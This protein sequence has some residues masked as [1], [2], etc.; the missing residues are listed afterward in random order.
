MSARLKSTSAKRNTR[1]GAALDRP[2]APDL[3]RRADEI[4]K[5]YQVVIWPE[6]GGYFGRGVEMP[7]V[8]ADGKTPAACYAAVYE[9]LKV[10]V[11]TLL[12]QGQT[13][14]PAATEG[15]RTEQVNVRLTP[16]ERLQL[17][18]AAKQRGY[19][20]LA[21]FFRAAAVSIANAPITSQRS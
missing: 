8:M 6:D 10:N 7:G 2:F 18:A 11:A 21:D 5:R 14:P 17:D 4:A 9:A 19:R 20:G 16:E 12:E 3:L 13:P 15:Q 1:R